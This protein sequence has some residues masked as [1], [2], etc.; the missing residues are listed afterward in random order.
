MIKIYLKIYQFHFFFVMSIQG[1]CCQK[2]YMQQKLWRKSTVSFICQINYYL[3]EQ[4]IFYFSESQDE[5]GEKEKYPLES[6]CMKKEKGE[7]EKYPLESDCMKKEKGEKA[8]PCKKVNFKVYFSYHC[9]RNF[10][11]PSLQRWQCI[12]HAGRG[13]LKTF[14]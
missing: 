10:K 7:K 12:I 9:E 6:D 5:K 1:I 4:H 13:T 3:R 14:W 2:F 11:W 8:G